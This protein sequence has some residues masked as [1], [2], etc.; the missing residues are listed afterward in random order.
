MVSFRFS[1]VLF[2]ILYTFSPPQTLLRFKSALTGT[3][4]GIDELTSNIGLLRALIVLMV[5]THCAPVFIGQRSSWSCSRPRLRSGG[6]RLR[7]R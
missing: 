5:F 6:N 7:R 2:L 4:V 3:E 1:D